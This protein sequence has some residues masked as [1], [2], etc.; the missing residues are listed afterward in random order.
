[1]LSRRL[2]V[3][4]RKLPQHDSEL[5]G[6]QTCLIV[7]TG[8]SPIFEIILKCGFIELLKRTALSDEL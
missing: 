3:E 1:M 2:L 7:Y 5:D 8:F 6:T 4:L